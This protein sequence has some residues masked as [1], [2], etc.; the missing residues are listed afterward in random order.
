MAPSSR[1]DNGH[2]SE[3]FIIILAPESL[4]RIQPVKASTSGGLSTKR[5]AGFRDRTKRI[6]NMAVSENETI[7]TIRGKTLREFEANSQ[8]RRISISSM[9]S[10]LLNIPR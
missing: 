6:A 8:Y 3:T 2:K 7:L 1:A 10:D 9:E 5:K 4:A